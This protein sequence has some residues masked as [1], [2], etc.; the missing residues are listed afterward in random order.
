MPVVRFRALFPHFFITWHKHLRA[1][2]M[3]CDGPPRLQ[4][5]SLHCVIVGT[6]CFLEGERFRSDPTPML[7]VCTKT[8]L[9]FYPVF[10]EQSMRGNFA[11]RFL[12]F[13][14]PFGAS[15]HHFRPICCWELTTWSQCKSTLGVRFLLLFAPVLCHGQS[16]V[17]V[18]M[19]SS[20]QA[21]QCS[22]KFSELSILAFTITQVNISRIL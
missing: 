4:F 11:W 18:A 22:Y 20:S 14:R 16:N 13:F 21:T 12:G 6:P 2:E 7:V 17:C 8:A 15:R 1:Q 3:L 9:F 5:L 19:F 10:T